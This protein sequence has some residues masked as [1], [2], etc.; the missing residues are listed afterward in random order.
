MQ[1]KNS[2]HGIIKITRI[3]SVLN[4]YENRNPISSSLLFQFGSDIEFTFTWTRS[5][6]SRLL[7]HDSSGKCKSCRRGSVEF[8]PT[9]EA[10]TASD[11]RSY[12]ISNEIR[13]SRR[14]QRISRAACSSV[15]RLVGC[16]TALHFSIRFDAT[17]RDVVVSSREVGPQWH[18]LSSSR[19][20]D[21]TT[22]RPNY[23]EA[24]DGSDYHPDSSE[25]SGLYNDNNTRLQ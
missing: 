16:C 19:F 7:C 24:T 2:K 6:L 3:V 25:Q 10:A 1:F 22:S 18:R 5:P 13:E 21:F 11:R 4:F 17:R 20:H 8:A 9:C 23:S 12:R 14:P 15:I